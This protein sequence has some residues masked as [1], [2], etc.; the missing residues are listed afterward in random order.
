MF[1]G[2]FHFNTSTPHCRST[3]CCLR[4]F[5]FL[6]FPPTT[7]KIKQA[8]LDETQGWNG[9][10]GKLLLSSTRG[11]SLQIKLLS[12]HCGEILYVVANDY[13][14]PGLQINGLGFK[15]SVTY[16]S[17]KITLILKGSEACEICPFFLPENIWQPYWFNDTLPVI[18]Y[19]YCHCCSCC[20]TCI[21]HNALITLLIKA[22]GW[23]GFRWLINALKGW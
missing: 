21:L 10:K 16:H 23:I 20:F 22:Y 4:T 18:S 13:I 14:M 19:N 1:K 15:Y 6:S 3:T 11:W 17:Q 9:M 8:F 5:F 2:F 7:P 12:E